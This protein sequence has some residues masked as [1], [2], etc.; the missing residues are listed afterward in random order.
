MRQPSPTMAQI[1]ETQI[2]TLALTLRPSTA[3]AYRVAC[4]RFLS[5]LSA[6]FPRVRQLS[7]L[8]RDPHLLGWF[9]SQCDP[10]PPLTPKTRQ[11]YLLCLRRLFDHLLLQGHPVQPNLICQ[12]DFPLLPKFLPRPLSIT[13]DQL[14]QQELQRTDD[15]L[16]NALLLTRATGIRVGECIDLT[17]DC[18]RAVGE[19]QWLMHVPLGKLHTER[20]VPAD[21]N[22]RRIIARIL[23]LRTSASLPRR[24]NGDGLLLP[25]CCSHRAFHSVLASALSD[26]ARRAGCS[27]RVTPHRLRHTFATEMIR[28]G[29]SLPALMQ[30]LGH[31]DIRMT[32]RY[33]EVTQLDLQRE[34]H[35]A[36]QNAAQ[37]RRMPAL[38][39][40]TA[41]IATGLPG[42]RQA[43]STARH[44]LEMYRRQ[45]SDEKQG[46]RLQRLDKRLLTVVSQLE[47]I[48]T[49]EK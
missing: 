10:P 9:R 27:T 13:D 32:L 48:A 21:E 28:Y 26:A 25:C 33:I 43:I 11:N 17:L 47:K 14:L 46:P 2:Q 7:E 18:L 40:P 15:L 19:N 12:Q 24:P 1:L 44:L 35:A 20:L 34:F 5:Y 45:L 38:P 39:V 41:V 31:K 23:S 16:S 4:R 49:A 37:S 42:I 6:A 29:V 8:R 36:R 3:V 30:M 22:I